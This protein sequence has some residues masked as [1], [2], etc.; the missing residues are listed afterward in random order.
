MV[1]SARSAAAPPHCPAPWASSAVGQL[2]LA[3][4]RV[5]EEKTEAVALECQLRAVDAR[6]TQQRLQSGR[7]KDLS[8]EGTRL[9][10][11]YA[12][13]EAALRRERNCLDRWAR[14]DAEAEASAAETRML[15]S[16][17]GAAAERTA[18][19]VD[20]ELPRLRAE[21]ADAKRDLRDQQ[22]ELCEVVALKV[23]LEKRRASVVEE[24]ACERTAARALRQKLDVR[25]WG[26]VLLRSTARR[27]AADLQ[28][29]VVDLDQQ[30]NHSLSEERAA[31]AWAQKTTTSSQKDIEDLGHAA[32]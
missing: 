31:L 14:S 30:I 20:E 5:A 28:G 22:E 16:E 10:L 11:E 27:H 13:L 3:R 6:V 1:L 9:S 15:R 24:V 19:L 17:L 8:A 21:A 18:G 32:P 25:G 2:A 26:L 12:E 4:R 29:S 7:L 23:S